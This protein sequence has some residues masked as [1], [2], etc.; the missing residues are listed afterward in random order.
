MLIISL[1]RQGLSAAGAGPHGLLHCHVAAI[2]AAP[3]PSV[4][5]ESIATCWARGVAQ[6]LRIREESP[7]KRED[8]I[9]YPSPTRPGCCHL[10]LMCSSAAR[11]N[12]PVGAARRAQ[13]PAH[14]IFSSRSHAYGQWRVPMD[15]WYGEG[16][17]R[18]LGLQVNSGAHEVLN[19]ICHTAF[20]AGATARGLLA[21]ALTATGRRRRTISSR[22]LASS[23]PSGE[24]PPTP[25][26]PPTHTHTRTHSAIKEITCMQIRQGWS[27]L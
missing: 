12:L 8:F 2:T 10:R 19:S 17:A 27:S 13:M 6:S 18:G 26:P 5:P 23:G 16:G 22:C 3:S 9:G 15:E 7:E 11:C 4:V 14:H 25:Q 21:V 20:A 24:L 1:V